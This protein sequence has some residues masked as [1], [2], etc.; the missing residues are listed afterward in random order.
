MCLDFRQQICKNLVRYDQQQLE[1]TEMDMLGYR[2]ATRK[3]T[4]DESDPPA[5]KSWKQEP[6][7]CL[8]HVWTTL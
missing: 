2:L 6:S 1:T 5:K 7:A 3:N 4:N 8:R